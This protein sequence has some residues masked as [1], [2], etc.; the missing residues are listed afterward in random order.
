[1]QC[2]AKWGAHDPR[3]QRYIKIFIENGLI[4]SERRARNIFS[5][6]RGALQK[7]MI[8]CYPFNPSLL[9]SITLKQLPLSLNMGVVIFAIE[10]LRMSE[11]TLDL[12][13]VKDA[14]F[15]V[16]NTKLVSS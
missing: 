15:K 3:K 6:H 2:N 7:T 9:T 12:H 1:M 10:I 5:F 16:E 14:T 8:F 13:L 11:T 4:Y